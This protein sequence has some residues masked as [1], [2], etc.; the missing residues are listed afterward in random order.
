MGSTTIGGGKRISAAV[1]HALGVL[2]CALMPLSCAFAQDQAQPV[3][4][5]IT[6]IDL[7]LAFPGTTDIAWPYSYVRLDS[8][9]EMQQ[10]RKSD[11]FKQLDELDWRLENGRYRSFRPAIAQWQAVIERMSSSR[12]PG[13]WSPAWLMA[14]PHQSPPVSS[15]VALGA[16]DVPSWVE[17]WDSKGVARVPWRSGLTLSELTRDIHPVDAGPSDQVAVVGS[18]GHVDHYGVAAWN[19]A[20]TRLVPGARVV[21]ALP[22]KGEGLIWIRD[23]I[24]RVLAHGVPG[25]G[26]REAP[27]TRN[28]SNG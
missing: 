22:L 7:W 28:V 8:T 6:L 16:C 20:D 12:V 4:R 5:D 19:F 3:P 27:F 13:S 25:D 23:A 1:R 26:C 17:V 15:L 18:G 2:L 9:D 14:H 10:A 11:L 21:A 24:A